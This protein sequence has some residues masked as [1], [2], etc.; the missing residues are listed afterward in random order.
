MTNTRLFA[1]ATKVAI[2]N[3]RENE[4]LRTLLFL[5]GCS[6]NA[7][8]RVEYYVDGQDDYRVLDVRVEAKPLS[9]EEQLI[10]SCEF[11][12]SP[13]ELKIA[14]EVDYWGMVSS[15]DF[16]RCCDIVSETY[17][18]DC[19]MTIEN[20]VLV[21]KSL[22]EYGYTLEHIEDMS[23]RARTD[24]YDAEFGDRYC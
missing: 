7:L 24:L 13:T 15:E 9:Y 2:E 22:L 6:K 10:T 5:E 1:K 17:F 4:E 19:D 16:N 23:P 12:I 14:Q 11:G 20:A 3:M 21:I 18:D 8:F